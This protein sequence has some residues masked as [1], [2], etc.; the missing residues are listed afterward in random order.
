[1]KP[2][3]GAME[4]TAAER[5]DDP[6]R[7]FTMKTFLGALFKQ[8]R[9]QIRRDE[10]L[11]N[12]Y[13]D[14]YGP[15]PFL[16]SFLIIM[17]SFMDALLTM[18]LLNNGAIELNVLMDW[19]INKD[20]QTFAIAKMAVTGV[21]IVVLVMHFN[22]RIYRIIAVRYVMYALVPVYM[23]LIAHEFNMLAQI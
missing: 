1:M 19:L 17:L 5:R 7:R 9:R 11:I 14:W 20:V 18:I 4:A 16:A 2:D 23:L 3:D 8:R 22:F 15:W 10:D 12:N 21:A 6:R 13:I